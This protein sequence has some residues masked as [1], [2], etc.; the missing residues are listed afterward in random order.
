MKFHMRA[1]SAAIATLAVTQAP[2]LA[3]GQFR[4]P[5]HPTL[6]ELVGSGGLATSG[7][8]TATVPGQFRTPTHPTLSEINPVVVPSAPIS[9]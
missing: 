9:R 3:Q 2:T 8:P 1:L 5:T 7:T 4:T 6:S